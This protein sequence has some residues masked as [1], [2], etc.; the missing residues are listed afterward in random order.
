MPR[1]RTISAWGLAASIML[2][3][4]CGA[5]GYT[6]YYADGT[7][8]LSNNPAS[9]ANCHI[10]NDQYDGWLKASHHAVATCN[11]CHV[12]H[13]M[14]GKYLTKVE[15]GYLHSKA[16]TLE[17]FHEPIQIRQRSKDVLRRNCI[18]CH[19]EMVSQIRNLPSVHGED[20]DCLH[21]HRSVGHGPVK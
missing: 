3:M 5:G 11:D 6:F 9:C 10:M 8:Y 20:A 16:F 2:G 1:Y 14:V 18:D 12:P 21:C 4:M 17:N 15:N 19:S 13:D 7:S